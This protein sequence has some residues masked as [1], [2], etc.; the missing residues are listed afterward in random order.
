MKKTHG[1]S[2][3]AEYR[4]PLV[5]LF[6]FVE[7]TH[8]ADVYSWASTPRLVLIAMVDLKLRSP[9]DLSPGPDGFQRFFADRGVLTPEMVRELIG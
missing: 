4:A 5:F 6:F 9:L 2:N 7:A 8:R 1:N 3:G